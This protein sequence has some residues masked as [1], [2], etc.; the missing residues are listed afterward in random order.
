MDPDEWKRFVTWACENGAQ[1]QYEGNCVEWRTPC[2]DSGGH[3]KIHRE[4]GPAVVWCDGGEEWWT[5]GQIR[6]VIWPVV[7]ADGRE[8]R[9]RVGFQ[10]TDTHR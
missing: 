2:E 3:G 7:L 5:N 1:S 4:N 9:C 6:R 8:V 10:D